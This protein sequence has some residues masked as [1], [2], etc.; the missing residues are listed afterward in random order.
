MT[1]VASPVRP[2]TSRPNGGKCGGFGSGRNRR[3]VDW[4][5]L[6]PDLHVLLEHLATITL[7]SLVEEQQASGLKIEERPAKR[8]ITAPPAVRRVITNAPN[9]VFAFGRSF[10]R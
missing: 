1:N 4:R 9:S 2:K 10:E 6:Q 8:A 5:Q 7:R 3:S